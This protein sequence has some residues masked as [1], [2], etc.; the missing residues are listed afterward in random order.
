VKQRLQFV[1]ERATIVI[2][3][4]SKTKKV[5]ILLWRKLFCNSTSTIRCIG[6]MNLCMFAGLGGFN[7]VEMLF[8]TNLLAIVGTGEQVPHYVD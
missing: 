5:V 2:L 3:L 7:I 8:G 1:S 6:F 4:F